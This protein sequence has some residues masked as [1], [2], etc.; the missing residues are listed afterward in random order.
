[1]RNIQ[2][3]NLKS[4]AKVTYILR[5]F[6]L[7]LKVDLTAFDSTSVWNIS[8]QNTCETL[9]EDLP[10]HFQQNDYYWLIIHL[11]FD[12]GS[13]QDGFKITQSVTKLSRVLFVAT[14]GCGQYQTCS[15]ISE[16][17]YKKDSAK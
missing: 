4:K 13:A 16:A 7:S 12:P 1:M 15:S 11:S 17:N 6:N 5:I 10:T 14:F 2:I 9:S 8:I 3:F